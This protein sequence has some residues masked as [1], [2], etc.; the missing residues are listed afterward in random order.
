MKSL[1]EF[2]KFVK[3]SVKSFKKISEM[4]EEELIEAVQQHNCLYDKSAQVYRNKLIKE[5]AWISVAAAA[6][7][8]G[9]CCRFVFYHIVLY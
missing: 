2:A 9:K 3:F 4:F 6:G 7:A 8:T 1:Q 5:K